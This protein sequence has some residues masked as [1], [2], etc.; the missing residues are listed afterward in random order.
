MQNAQYP[1]TEPK[2]KPKLTAHLLTN[3][4]LTFVLGT[5]ALKSPLDRKRPMKIYP[6]VVH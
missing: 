3:L 2:L 4:L 1:Q 5:F 6:E